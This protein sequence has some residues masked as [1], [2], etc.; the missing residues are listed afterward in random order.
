MESYQ[1]NEDDV[2]MELAVMKELS[3]GGGHPNVLFLHDTL[4]P[5]DS[6]HSLNR[7]KGIC[8]R[9][10]GVGRWRSA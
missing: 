1:W 2:Q 8:D 4:G 10:D 6:F 3:E 5:I 7:N 9:G